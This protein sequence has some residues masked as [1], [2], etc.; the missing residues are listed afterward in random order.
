MSLG[1]DVVVVGGGPAGSAAAIWSASCGLRT[2]LIER[3]RFPRHR[4]G[5]TLHPGAESILKQLGVEA[6]V[7]AASAIRHESIRIDWAGSR[8]NRAFG[9]DA[10]GQ[11]RGYQI[12]RDLL[13]TILIERARELGVTVLRD[14]SAAKPVFENERVS[15]V[16]VAESTIAGR[17]VVDATGQAAWLKRNLNL[18]YLIASPP[19]HAF[20]GYH[21]G[22][23]G[24]SGLSPSITG[25]A[26]GWTW[27]AQIAPGRIQWT[28]VSLSGEKDMRSPPS[29]LVDSQFHD[30]GTRGANVTWRCISTPAGRG[31]FV[32]GDAATVL[33]PA[34]SKGV[35]RALMSGMMASHTIKQIFSSAI[36]ECQARKEYGE[37]LATSFVSDVRQLSAFYRQLVPSWPLTY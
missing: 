11:W 16:H 36:D 7:A 4:P 13:D 6:Q 2:Y 20:Y 37:W 8:S 21:D 24:S 30:R 18:Q 3:S 27:M 29:H 28:R 34:S 10:S 5:E 15:G 1:A 25:D 12:G 19:L 22:D 23:L 26:Q 14:S 31:Y 9:S 35:L 33:D 17:F 32:V